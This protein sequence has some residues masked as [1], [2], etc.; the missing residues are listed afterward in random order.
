MENDALRKYLD[1]TSAFTI[2]ASMP[3]SPM[4]PKLLRRRASELLF[5]AQRS[6]GREQRQFPEQ[7]TA[8]GSVRETDNSSVS[9]STPGAGL[10]SA[11]LGDSA[12]ASDSTTGGD[13]ANPFKRSQSEVAKSPEQT[14]L[15]KMQLAQYK[16]LANVVNEKNE[17]M[18]DDNKLKIKVPGAGMRRSIPLC[19]HSVLAGHSGGSASHHVGMGAVTSHQAS[20]GKRGRPALFLATVSSIRA[21]MNRAPGLQLHAKELLKADRCTLFVCDHVRVIKSSSLVVANPTCDSHRGSLFRK[22]TA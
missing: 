5:E 4:P 11:S 7:G 19:K 9:E 3:S 22:S 17:R 12:D 15:L 1:Q 6:S 10:F 14:V 16:V 13:S 8:T 20:A 2:S 21:E 18:Q